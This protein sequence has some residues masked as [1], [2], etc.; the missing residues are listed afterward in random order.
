MLTE[1]IKLSIAVMKLYRH[2]RSSCSVKPSLG[3]KHEEHHTLSAVYIFILSSQTTIYHS[4]AEL[5]I[6]FGQKVLQVYINALVQCVIVS[7]AT[8]YSQ[9]HVQY[10]LKNQ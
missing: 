5:W 8:A 6:L 4:A 3:N 2:I 10:T 1:L 9:G 7:I